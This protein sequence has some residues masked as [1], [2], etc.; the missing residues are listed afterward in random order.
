MLDSTIQAPQTSYFERA[1]QFAWSCAKA[2]VNLTW[3]CATSTPVK[4]VAISLIGLFSGFPFLPEV[5]YN[6]NALDWSIGSYMPNWVAPVYQTLLL[7]S[8]NKITNVCETIFSRTVGDNNEIMVTKLLYHAAAEEII[9]REIIQNQILPRVAKVLP[10]KVGNILAHPVTRVALSSIIFATA[11]ISNWNKK[12]G[13]MP[14]LMAGLI[15]GAAR[16]I[17][18]GLTLPIYVHAI[19]NLIIPTLRYMHS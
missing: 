16:E 18:G 6:G 7:G 11:H 12:S 1:S 8:A 15:Y 9:C 3:S 2:P 14:Q 17:S 19:E 5:K 13:V 4:G 10:E